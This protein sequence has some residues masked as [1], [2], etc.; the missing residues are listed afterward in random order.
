[1]SILV[2]QLGAGEGETYRAF[3]LQALEAE[4]MAFASDYER[5][6]ALPPEAFEKT[7]SECAIFAAFADEAMA[8]MA[9]FSPVETEKS[10]HIGHLFGVYVIPA[11]RGRGLGAALI[12]AVVSHAR[13][14]VL[15]LHLGV[16]TYNAPAIALYQRMGF[17]IFGTE[18]RSL[19]VDG[20]YIDEHLMVRFL[21]K[22]DRS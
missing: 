19:F 20:H 9:G 3:R 1:M 21:D 17:E 10:R 4:P 6:A 11:Q 13:G 18:P 14:K 5:E 8:G 16:G 7:L 15:Q 2:R 12:D 22:E